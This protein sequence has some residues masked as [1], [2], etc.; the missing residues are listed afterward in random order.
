MGDGCGD[1]SGS[2]RTDAR[3]WLA[4]RFESFSGCCGPRLRTALEVLRIV[5]HSLGVLS[6]RLRAHA[7]QEDRFE[8]RWTTPR[9]GL[10][11]FDCR[12]RRILDGGSV[13]VAAQQMQLGRA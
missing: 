1:G 2:L 6:H 8:R 13:Q 3:G 12:S 11:V 4:E 10:V 7:P 5:A 9:H